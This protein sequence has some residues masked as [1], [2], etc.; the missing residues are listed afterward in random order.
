MAFSVEIAGVEKG[1]LSAGREAVATHHG[2]Y[3]GIPQTFAALEAW[4]EENAV[5]RE[6]PREVYL[7]DPDSV[8]MA[9]RVTEIVYPI[10]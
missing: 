8:P 7:S 5:A 4:V 6:A 10:E 9:D 2:P 3:K 1:T